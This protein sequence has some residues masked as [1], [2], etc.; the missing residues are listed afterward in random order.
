MTLIRWSPIRDL[1]TEIFDLQKE[2]NRMFDRFFRGF[3]DEE[4]RMIS[5]SPRVDISETDDEYIVRAE[6]PG[7]S[8]DDVKITIKDDILTISGEKKQEKEAKGENFHRIERVYG[9]FSRS[10]ALPGSVKVDKVEAKFKDGVL[11]IKLPKVE[12]AKPR[13]IEIKVD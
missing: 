6:I 5:W 1:A 9:S 3:E 7:V 4:I 11:T 12:E 10:F 2:I 13:E 8:K